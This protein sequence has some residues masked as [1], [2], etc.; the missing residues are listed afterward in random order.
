MVWEGFRN[1]GKHNLDFPSGRKMATDY[2]QM[3]EFHLLQFAEMI[4]S[5]SWIFQQDNALIHVS[6]ILLGMF[7]WIMGCKSLNGMLFRLISL[8]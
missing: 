8:P 6:H 1:G 2:Q 5:L 4:G 3:L 7:F